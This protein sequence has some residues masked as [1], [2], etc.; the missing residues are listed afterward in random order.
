MSKTAFLMLKFL[1]KNFLLYLFKKIYIKYRNKNNSILFEKILL[2]M[3]IIVQACGY[4]NL[5][6]PEL[7]EKINKTEPK[8][9][10][11]NLLQKRKKLIGYL[12]IKKAY[13][14]F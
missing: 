1:F 14:F 5:N 12:I 4:F 3:D 9:N 7:I 13:I 10:K 2:N 11:L 8:S 6:K